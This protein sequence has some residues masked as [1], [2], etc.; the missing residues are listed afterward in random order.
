MGRPRVGL[1]YR[2]LRCAAYPGSATFLIFLEISIQIHYIH[3]I[4]AYEIIFS[5]YHLQAYTAPA[6]WVCDKS[7]LPRTRAMNSSAS[8]NTHEEENSY[9]PILSRRRSKRSV[10]SFQ[11]GPAM[12]LSCKPRNPAQSRASYRRNTKIEICCAI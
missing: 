12:L 1:E 9:M 10:Q 4:Q 5:L 6:P 8:Q 2:H 11:L 7:Q 3:P